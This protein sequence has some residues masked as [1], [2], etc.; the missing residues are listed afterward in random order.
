MK[1]LTRVALEFIKYYLVSDRAIVYEISC[2]VF[3]P[4]AMTLPPQ[5]TAE[6]GT[7]RVL[8]SPINP[9]DIHRSSTLPKQFLVKSTSTDSRR[10]RISSE[11]KDS[12]RSHVVPE[13]RVPMPANHALSPSQ[14][15]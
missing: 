13:T 11:M 1:H 8:L 7:V 3:F 6:W 2:V 14:V 9:S 10:H 15:G 4:Y 12:G 5:R